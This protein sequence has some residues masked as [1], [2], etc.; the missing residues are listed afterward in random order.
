LALYLNSLSACSTPL[1][2]PEITE[3]KNK[4]VLQWVDH[5]VLRE[6]LWNLVV[7]Y[8][9]LLPESDIIENLPLLLS[10]IESQHQR[11]VIVAQM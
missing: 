1:Y 10:E 6:E 7:L 8:V 9:S 5:L 11:K 2:M 4:I 3:W